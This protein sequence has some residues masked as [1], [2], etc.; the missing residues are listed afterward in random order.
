MMKGNCLGRDN[1]FPGIAVEIAALPVPIAVDGDAVPQRSAGDPAEFWRD[2]FAALPVPHAYAVVV[3]AEDFDVLGE[4]LVLAVVSAVG[5][6][7]PGACEK[8]ADEEDG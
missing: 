1:N 2:I 4:G 8:G 5:V 6:V 3:E 7:V